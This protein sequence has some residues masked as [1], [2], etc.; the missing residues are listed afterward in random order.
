MRIVIATPFYPPQTG[1]LAT[2]A[3]GLEEA[4]IRQGHEVV[5]VTFK[6]A[7]P[8]LVRHL[9]YF[10][11]IFLA[12]R[13][14]SFVLALDTWSV[15]MP[16]FFAA[17]MRKVPFM[18]RVGGDY[19]WERYLERTH[20]ALR[21]SEFYT[22]SRAYSV[23][24]RCMHLLITRMLAS[25]HAVMFNT[26]FQKGIWCAAY[27]IPHASVLE[28]FY[29]VKKSA[30]APSNREFVSAHRGAWYKNPGVMENAFAE[31][32]A[33]HPDIV[34]DTRLV[35]HDDQLQRLAAS[36]AVVIPS[37]SEVGSNTAIEAVA[38]GRP[39]IM[40]DDTGTSERLEG[41][42]LFVDTRDPKALQRAIES[43]L[44]PAV[45]AKLCTNI[46]AF[47]YTRSWDDIAAE[48]LA[49]V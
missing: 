40:S 45:Y 49:N 23:R 22:D 4:F 21:F 35:P 8:P 36:Y 18:V 31:V 29:P 3:A 16:A 10:I 12:L 33:R 14:A 44:D 34:L 30:A 6:K 19:L 32:K 47:A 27:H 41:C 24:E 20:E 43:L 38:A 48:I 46:A 25:A 42:G 1:I 2:Y 28:N 15:G 5:V 26:E 17:R 37:I 9:A 7:L 11:R 13:G 39:F